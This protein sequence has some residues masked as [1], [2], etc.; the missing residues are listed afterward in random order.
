MKNP[1]RQKAD[2]KKNK[3][4][5]RINIPVLTMQNE[6]SELIGEDSFPALFKLGKIKE[7]I[8]YEPVEK[9]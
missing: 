9:F 7:D 3:L 4:G 2:N 8:T 6:L 5:N 1:T